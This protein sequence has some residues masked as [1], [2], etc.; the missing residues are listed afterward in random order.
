MSLRKVQSDVPIGLDREAMTAGTNPTRTRGRWPWLAGVAVVV[1]LIAGGIW[2]LTGDSTGDAPVAS[3]EL[4]LAE[5]VVTDLTETEEFAGTLGR[6][7]SDPVLTRIGGTVTSTAAEGATVDQGDVL[8][9]IDSQPVVLLYGGVPAYRTLSNS[10]DDGADV[11]QLEAALVALGYDPD[12]TVTVDQEFTANTESM[13]ERWQQDIGAS[14][15]GVVNLG[16]VVFLPSAIRVTEVLAAPGSPVG[17]GTPILGT[18]A[19]E[20][21]VTVDLP[22]ADQGTLVE[23]AAVTVVL[24]DN[25]TTSAVVTSVGTV[26]TQVPGGDATFEV[27]VTLDDPSAAASLDEA[28]VDVEVVTDSREGVLAVPVTALIALAEGG[29]AVEV[30][31]GS[32]QTT[33]VAVEPGFYSGGMVE[34][35]SPSL[36]P[37]DLVVVP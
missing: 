35:D 16:E 28:P 24:P 6:S 9:E 27:V 36:N 29:Y 26:A 31:Q 22:A 37:G 14:D 3:G 23:G 25:S 7:P 34:I 17:N 32:G 13:V 19:Q 5:V 21:V 20:T 10:A 11:E 18:S 4:D 33:L 15:D 2:L 30:D 1:A 12:E 8:Y